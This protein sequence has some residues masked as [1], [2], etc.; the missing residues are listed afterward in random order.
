MCSERVWS[1]PLG[2]AARLS[3]VPLLWRRQRGHRGQPAHRRPPARSDVVGT[4]TSRTM[5]GV[6]LG[7]RAAS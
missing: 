7:G 6:P 3:S 4:S 2:R 1:Q 5:L